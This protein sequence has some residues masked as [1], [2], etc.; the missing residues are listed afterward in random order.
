MTTWLPIETA[1][2]DNKRPLYLARFV[3]GKMVELTFNGGWEYW[4]ESWEMPHINGWSWVS[5]GGIQEPTH[6]AYQDAG[7]PPLGVPAPAP[8]PAPPARTVDDLQR[9]LLAICRGGSFADTWRKLN[10]EGQWP[11]LR[12][13]IGR[14]ARLDEIRRQIK[15]INPNA[16]L[17]YGWGGPGDTKP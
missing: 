1:P 15:A 14:Q 7:P 12:G 2:T 16:A 10:A 4:Q 17:Y 6:W 13:E 9:E 8:E 5:D 3:D 11:S